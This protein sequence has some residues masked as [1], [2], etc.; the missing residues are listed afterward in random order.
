MNEPIG[1]RSGQRAYWFLALVFLAIVYATWYPGV[2]TLDE[3]DIYQQSLNWT[4][5]DGH[6]PLIVLLWGVAQHIKAGPALPY[7]A[8]VTLAL[9]MAAALL[10]RL[11]P[12]ARSAAIGMA[13]LVFMPPVFVSLGLVTKDIFFIGAMLA[14]LVTG[15]RFLE[16][17]S[18]TRLAALL[19]VLLLAIM[20]RIDAAFA[21]FPVVIYFAW[22]LLQR[23]GV[24]IAAAAASAVAIATALI[25]TLLLVSKVIAYKVFHA[26]AYHSEQ[27][28][29][30]FDLSAL[31]TATNE[32]L[33]PTSRLGPKG[34]PLS[35]LRQRINPTSADSLI[36]NDDGY[37]LVYRPQADHDELRNAWRGAILA[38][39]REYVAFR[40]EY[41]A[42]FIGIRNNVEWLHGQFF[43]DKMMARDTAHGWS[44][45]GSM[46]HS[47]YY[48]LSGSPAWQWIY[49]PWVALLFALFPLAVFGRHP[50]PPVPAA[51]RLPGSV[52][53]TLVASA[54]CYTMAMAIV[55]SG[56]LGRYHAWP[57]M[58]IGIALV[59]ACAHALHAR[60]V[61]RGTSAQPFAVPP[62]SE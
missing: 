56:T 38:H 26:S 35:L 20:V 27:V 61:Q 22:T 43:G 50:A 46:L 49:L 6:S 18:T 36:W 44:T 17:T 25:L 62:I 28:T 30:L 15:L 58:A 24:R 19:A 12:T 37:H 48:A 29:M 53:I 8:G 7:L 32:Q 3:L 40:A 47:V 10:W 57:R 33:L 31:S 42:R 5:H 34:Y 4:M 1:Q 54:F 55:S 51:A 52:A 45:N 16:R 59:L 2:F 60:F 39:P 23:R 14:V 11:L 41:A 9:S 13:A 21:L